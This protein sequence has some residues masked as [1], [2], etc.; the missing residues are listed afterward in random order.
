MGLRIHV[1]RGNKHASGHNDLGW[2]V[3]TCT[4]HDASSLHSE[5]N[6]SSDSINP[7]RISHMA[8]HL[9]FLIFFKCNLSDFQPFFLATLQ[10]KISPSYTTA[11][12]GV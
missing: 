12:I 8:L 5:P 4:N 3:K 2:T 11:M 10:S 6:S 7:R 9:I 1:G